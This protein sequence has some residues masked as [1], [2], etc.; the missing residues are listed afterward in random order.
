MRP[1]GTSR[2]PDLI[3]FAWDSERND[4]RQ[5][6]L[7]THPIDENE[8]RRDTLS[9]L[10]GLLSKYLEAC[11]C[12]LPPSPPHSPLTRHWPVPTPLLPSSLCA[13]LSSWHF[14]HN[15]MDDSFIT[16]W[17]HLSNFG[18]TDHK[19]ICY[20]LKDCWRTST[21]YKYIYIYFISRTVW[22]NMHKEGNRGG[23]RRNPT[24]PRSPG[25]AVSLPIPTGF[26]HSSVT[27]EIKGAFWL[28]A[29]KKIIIVMKS[30]SHQQSC[31]NAV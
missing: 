17:H 11:D 2:R 10:N 19:N 6:A 31:D 28:T 20:A 26:Y 3:Y 14:A 8:T 15:K 13:H 1:K 12:F 29:I 4:Y 9:L 27:A 5:S 16:E 7:T 22:R 21:L 24:Q 23:G 30:L 25:L 18:I